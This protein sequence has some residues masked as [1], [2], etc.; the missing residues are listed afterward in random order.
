[1]VARGHCLGDHHHHHRMIV[2][3]WLVLVLGD[4][5]LI[6]FIATKV[7]YFVRHCGRCCFLLLPILN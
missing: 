4:P 7:F 2:L 5:S 3:G 1:M 6:Y